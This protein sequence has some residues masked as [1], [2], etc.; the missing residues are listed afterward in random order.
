M[1][2]VKWLVALA[3]MASACVAAENEDASEV[4][5]GLK[6][7][8]G[9]ELS[10]DEK[11]TARIAA[12]E[13]LEKIR[14]QR[15]VGYFPADRL[16]FSVDWTDKR[17]LMVLSLI[18]QERWVRVLQLRF[19]RQARLKFVSGELSM[20]EPNKDTGFS[21]L[22]FVL[23]EDGVTKEQPFKIALHNETSCES[24]RTAWVSIASFAIEL[25][26]IQWA[27]KNK[28]KFVHAANS[29]AG[30]LMGPGFFLSLTTP[31]GILKFAI[32]YSAC[33]AVLGIASYMGVLFFN[34]MFGELVAAVMCRGL[35]SACTLNDLVS[36]DGKHAWS[37]A[38]EIYYAIPGID[39]RRNLT[40]HWADQSFDLEVWGKPQ[41]S[42]RRELWSTVRM[43][44]IRTPDAALYSLFGQGL[45]WSDAE[46]RIQ[47]HKL[48]T[49]ELGLYISHADPKQNPGVKPL[50]DA[51]LSCL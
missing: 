31:Q 26:E 2:R 35:T 21:A 4:N 33:V 40:R 12:A 19:E 23:Y 47:V 9:Q 3:C 22:S 29:C 42:E 41:K 28:D 8:L 43:Q 18:Q 27:L 46:G 37:Q 13:I 44:R 36:C 14:D 50:L 16:E 45:S 15:F 34:Q 25:K 1:Q 5:D 49:D 20:V 30:K 7:D 38:N 24:C 39:F 10:A 11:S 6:A 48:P 17:F 32:A 51:R